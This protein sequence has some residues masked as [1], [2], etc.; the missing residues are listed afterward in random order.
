VDLRLLTAC[1]ALLPAVVAGCGHNDHKDAAP[2]QVVQ[3]PQKSAQGCTPQGDY[4]ISITGG[5][6]AC[7]DAYAIASKYDLQGDKYQTI[8]GFQ[9]ASGTADVRPLIFECISD[10][11]EFGVYQS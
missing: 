11:A 6:I 2:T 1:V 7:A 4:Q 3:T 10:S 8:D 5:T 9:C